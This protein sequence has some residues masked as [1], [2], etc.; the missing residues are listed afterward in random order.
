MEHRYTR[1]E[2]E[3]MMGVTR[4]ELDYWTRLRLVLPRARWGERFFNFS[5]LVALET[6]KRLASRKVPARR[7]RRAVTALQTELGSTATPLSKLR[8]STNGKQVVVYPPIETARPYE[9]LTGQFVL[10]FETSALANKVHA[11][12]PR[13]AEEWFELGMMCDSDT[14]SLDQAVQ[15]YRKAVEGAP[16]W[17]EARINLGT[18]L[19][20]MGLMEEAQEQFTIAVETDPA[21]ALAEFNLGCVFEQIGNTEEAIL[22]LVRAVELAPSLADAHLNLALAYERCGEVR[23]AVQHLSLYLRY[24]PNGPWTE[25]AR[26]RIRKYQPSGPSSPSGKLTPFRRT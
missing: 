16:D 4:R 12:A 25:F 2:V 19:Y 18:S 5:D 14:K 1:N 20:Q 9:P 22:H 15:A 7:I 26:A 13:S 23:S 6:I 17:V 10:N 8:I 3:R 24:E 11:L 21:N